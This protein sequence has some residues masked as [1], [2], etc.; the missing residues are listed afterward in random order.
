MVA[1]D[2]LPPDVTTGASLR[3]KEYGWSVSAFPDAVS[4]AGKSGYAC[5][6][7]QFQFRLDDGATCEMYWLNA[8][9]AER[10]EGESWTDYSRRSCAQVLQRFQSL[11]SQ[12]DFHKEA[13]AW[14]IQ[15]DPVKNLV[16]VAYFVREKDCVEL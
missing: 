8:D 11:V 1:D 9:A 15:I 16:F 5:L 4:K 6:G 10:A 14:P 12:T 7:G 13:S 2:P 3:G